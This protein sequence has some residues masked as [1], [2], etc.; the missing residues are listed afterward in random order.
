MKLSALTNGLLGGSLLSGNSPGSQQLRNA[1][2]VAKSLDPG[3]PAFQ[4]HQVIDKAQ[5]GDYCNS[6]K[7]GLKVVKMLASHAPE[8]VTPAIADVCLNSVI[9]GSSS[10]HNHRKYYESGRADHHSFARDLLNVLTL[11]D[12]DSL[13]G[14]YF[15][16]F[17]L[18]GICPLPQT[19]DVD[20]SSWWPEKPSGLTVPPSS[21]ETFKVL[22]V[23]DIHL[24]LDYTPG[25]EANCLGMM[26]CV[27]DVI[28]DPKGDHI[29]APKWGYYTCDAPNI[30]MENSLQSVHHM[31]ADQQLSE[32]DASQ[33]FSRDTLSPTFNLA[34]VGNGLGKL[35]K[36]LIDMRV[37]KRDEPCDEDLED[38]KDTETCQTNK[39]FDF[40][41]MNYLSSP[42][43]HK[44]YNNRLFE[45]A[46]FTG[47]MIDHNP[48]G[49]SKSQ[50]IAEE[51]EVMHAL[52]THLGDTPVY[53]VLG[54]HDSYP[55]SQVAQQSS[56]FADQFSFNA[57]LMAD[58][59]ADY[60]W[61]DE[62][63]AQIA[64]LHYG[65]YSTRAYPGLR[66]ISLNSNFWYRWNLYNYWDTENPDQSESLRFLTK[67]L[68]ECEKNGE[69]AWVI[70]HVPPG[71]IPNDVLPVQSAALTQILERFSP[72]TIAGIFFGHTHMDEFTVLYRGDGATKSEENAINVAW[73]A[74][75]ITP[76]LRFNPSWRYYE[77]DSSS[78][79]IMNSYTYFTHLN[80][81]FEDDSP[82]EWRIAYSA[83]DYIP[84][85]PES[86]PLN[87]KFWHIVSE[88][89]RSD[90]QFAQRFSNNKFR[91]SPYSPDC[92]NHQCIYENYC[93]TTSMSMDQAINCRL[94]HGIHMKK[95]SG[96]GPA[97]PMPK[98]I[99]EYE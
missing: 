64:K 96:A 72:E 55:F 39:R 78:F 59:W 49:I 53:A 38:S 91:F 17:I 52:R 1:E 65:A 37:T 68:L 86:E 94:E 62:K 83:R 11:M 98:P 6:C 29:S 93:Y 9:R 22:H 69:R 40:D 41:F 21:G 46:L 31:L 58:L 99:R 7:H 5:S 8:K 44:S 76:L 90:P 80:D 24:S 97:Y 71:G 13:D 87:G 66:V 28:K 18:E 82:P 74:P 63:N 14:D 19:P 89:I 61:I 54:N 56:G 92:T 47:D 84:S 73:V 34:T 50:S 43:S 27:P 23:S 81:T 15:C 36:Q 10:C 3:N 75:S 70:A 85:W 12:P 48:L 33:H 67:E 2:G 20:L 57:D 51:K 25:T 35:G 45:F 4:L 32:L 26:C 77:V 60:G 42:S 16:H 79:E 30:L 88:N 95:L